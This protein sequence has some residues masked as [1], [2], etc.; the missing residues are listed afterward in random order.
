MTLSRVSNEV[1]PFF[2]FSFFRPFVHLFPKIPAPPVGRHDD[3]DVRFFFY[4]LSV[5]E[6]E[7]DSSFRLKK[8]YQFI[9]RN[10]LLPIFFFLFFFLVQLL[11]AIPATPETDI[12]IS[13][14]KSHE[15]I[16]KSPNNRCNKSPKDITKSAVP[17]PCHKM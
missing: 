5:F 15:N 9:L 6:K 13:W 1:C 4:P 8:M 11:P 3:S 10:D 7:R 14:Q 12:R 17:S 2:S 16:I